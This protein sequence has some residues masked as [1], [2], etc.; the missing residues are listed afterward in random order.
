MGAEACC[1][2]PRTDTHTPAGI[3]SQPGSTGELQKSQETLISLGVSQPCRVALLI[4][5]PNFVVLTGLQGASTEGFTLGKTSLEKLNL[6][7]GS[8]G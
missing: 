4:S 8:H 1:V 5:G 7:T 6:K 3:T 2:M